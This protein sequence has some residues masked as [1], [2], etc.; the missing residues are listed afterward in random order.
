M[1]VCFAAAKRRMFMQNSMTETQKVMRSEF[2]ILRLDFAEVLKRINKLHAE[3]VNLKDDKLVET[4]EQY[5]PQFY[6]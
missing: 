6:L 4:I 3:A 2:D 5:W 1:I